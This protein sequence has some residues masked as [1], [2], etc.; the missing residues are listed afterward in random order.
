[1]FFTT[2]VQE[3]EATPSELQNVRNATIAE[4]VDI[5]EGFETTKSGGKATAVAQP[6]V[7]T[8]KDV[9]AT[10]HSVADTI[11]QRVTRSG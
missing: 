6:A 10:M 9:K 7:A 2:P 11:A 1:M 4:N 8:P 5:E 3:E